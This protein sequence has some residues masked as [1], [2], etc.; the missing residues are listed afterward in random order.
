MMGFLD[1]KLVPN[2]GWA[3]T[4]RNPRLPVSRY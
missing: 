2:S 4:G 1:E 3:F